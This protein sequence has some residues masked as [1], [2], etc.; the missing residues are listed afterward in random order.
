MFGYPCCFANGNMF[1][2]LHEQR[3][4]LR[5]PPGQHAELLA[6]GGSQFEPV[7]GRP[8]RGYAALPAAVVAD[9]DALKAWVDRAF[10]HALS[11]PPKEKKAPRRKQAE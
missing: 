11:L 6:A 8:M 2:G 3:F 1:M 9:R 10:T 4:I 7:A 5:L